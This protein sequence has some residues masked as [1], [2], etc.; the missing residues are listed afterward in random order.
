[1][2][3]EAPESGADAIRSN[4]QSVVV[5][6]IDETVATTLHGGLLYGVYD[7]LAIEGVLS[8]TEISKLEA[9]VGD[10]LCPRVDYED[11]DSQWTVVTNPA[12]RPRDPVSASNSPLTKTDMVSLD[13]DGFA[14]FL[15]WRGDSVPTFAVRTPG[16]PASRMSRLRLDGADSLFGTTHETTMTQVL[17]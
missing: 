10:G 3:A 14:R 2:S 7:L 12:F 17:L 9:T 1:M 11:A 13:A 15:G 6:D 16:T 8:G 5:T 4:N